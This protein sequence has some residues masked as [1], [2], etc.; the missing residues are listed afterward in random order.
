M[1]HLGSEG[2]RSHDPAIGDP[3]ATP[4]D[5]TEG[6]TRS[7]CINERCELAISSHL[8]TKAVAKREKYIL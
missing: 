4:E 6:W 8:V 5:V 2:G 3:T 1:R 7:L